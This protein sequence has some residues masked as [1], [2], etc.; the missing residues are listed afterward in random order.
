MAQ[1]FK[2]GGKVYRVDSI[3]EV[4]MADI[5]QFNAQSEDMGLHRSWA[6]VER[7]GDEFTSLSD[8]EAE[9][10]PAK[11]LMITATIWAA[12]R[13]AGEDI[14]LEEMLKVKP[15]KD[16]EFLPDTADRKPGKAK[17]SKRAPAKPKPSDSAAADGP[18]APEE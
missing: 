10:H 15:Y 5:L 3:D 17:G 8:A 13:I 7:L 9:T 14:T 4:T 2:V 16:L 11:H 6:D 1:R 12:R 18:E